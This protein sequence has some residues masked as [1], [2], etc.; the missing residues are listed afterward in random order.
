[1]SLLLGLLSIPSFSEAQRNLMSTKTP[2]IAGSHYLSSNSTSDQAAI[3][4][5]RKVIEASGGMSAWNNLRSA[6]V[7]VAVT[8]ADVPQPHELLMLDDWSSD[9]V[10]YRR[11]VMGAKKAPIDH[12]AKAA[13]TVADGKKE[14]QVPEFDQAR[15]LV[16]HMPA[17]AAEV[18]LRK[19]SYV[20][21]QVDAAECKS[22][23][24]CIDI[25][26]QSSP[27]APFVREQEWVILQATSLPDKVSVLLPTLIGHSEIW[28]ETLFKQM[29][30]QNGL[31]IPGEVELRLPGGRTQ[32]H[33]L[34]SFTPNTEF[35]AAAFDQE[36]AK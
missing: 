10:M 8:S 32:T 5:L 4:I 18:I 20:V 26:R 17:A 1:V 19:N 14:R 2:V 35:N 31:T 22:G 24:L 25:Y 13:F 28:K 15:I 7:R 30:L 9:S 3:Q 29:T 16:G 23:R 27:K 12:S 33:T 36:L 11:G 21:K 34:V 6:K